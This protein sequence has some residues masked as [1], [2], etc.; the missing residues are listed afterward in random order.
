M[1]TED[2]H[3]TELQHGVAIYHLSGAQMH[4][5]S[6][7]LGD[8]RVAA[9]RVIKIK[10]VQ[11]ELLQPKVAGWVFVAEHGQM[12]AGNQQLSL[13]GN[14]RGQRKGGGTLRAG[15][16]LVDPRSGSVKLQDGFVLD[17]NN[18]HERGIATALNR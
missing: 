17:S 13:W 1:Q 12:V 11:L 16:L 5:E 8:L 15:R 4:D 3:Y 2:F 7:R 18:R 9:M 10:K 14:V 6:G